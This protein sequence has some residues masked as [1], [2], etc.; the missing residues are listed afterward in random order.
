VSELKGRID[1]EHIERMRESGRFRRT[2]ELVVHSIEEGDAERVVGYALSL[3]TVTGMLREGA[4]EDELGLT[5]LRSVAERTIGDR[6]V[7]WFVGYR[8]RV[9]IR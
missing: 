8:L 4:T 9:G 5:E 1:K 7:P 2:R 6:P 3:G